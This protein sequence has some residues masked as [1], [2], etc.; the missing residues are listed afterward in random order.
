MAPGS[1]AAAVA[2]C[3]SHRRRRAVGTGMGNDTA[4]T[5]RDG[6]LSSLVATAARRVNGRARVRWT[7]RARPSPEP[8]GSAAGPHLDERALLQ[9]AC[10]GDDG[11]LEVLC[12][13][14]WFGV[15]RLVCATVPDPHEAEELTQEVFARAIARLS[16]VP[17]ADGSFGG[18]LAR[19]ARGLL[20]G[21]W[22]DYQV[23]QDGGRAAGAAE[24]PETVV[25]SADDW[26]QLTAAIGRL[27]D[28]SRELLHLG[29]LEG[30]TDAEIGAEWGRTPE[31]V[32]RAQRQALLA[33]QSEMEGRAAR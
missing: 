7:D 22:R 8:E 10:L 32:H 26:G 19:I 21:R 17:Y 13:R 14:E 28:R 5:T 11:S 27:P 24:E 6:G 16:D 3:L 9:G 4:V 30:R 23:E 1:A 33:L 25:L 29:F 20:Q 18:Y 12:R 2:H 15:Y 31:D